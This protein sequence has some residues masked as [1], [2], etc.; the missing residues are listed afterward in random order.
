MRPPLG[1]SALAHASS[2][3]LGTRAQAILEL[4]APQLSVFAAHSIPASFSQ[5]NATALADIVAIADGAVSKLPADDTPRPLD[6]GAG[7]DPPSMGIAV[8]LASATAGPN[9]TR[10]SQAAQNQL[11]FVLSSLPRA[12]DGAISHRAEQVQLWADFVYMTPPFIAVRP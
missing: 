8:L 3:E 2:W 4:D 10:Y 11:A 7:G 5:A 1:L 9:A 6:S 12:P